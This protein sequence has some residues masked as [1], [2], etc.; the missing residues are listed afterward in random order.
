MQA[1]VLV[2][3]FSIYCKTVFKG[4]N[5]FYTK[6]KESGPFNKKEQCY[7]ISVV[8]NGMSFVLAEWTALS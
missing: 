2:L 7:T 6:K 3:P 1:P 8:F 5:F 4:T